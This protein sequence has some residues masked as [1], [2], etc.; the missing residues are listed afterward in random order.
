MNRSLCSG[1]RRTFAAALGV[2]AL[3]AAIDTYGSVAL[4]AEVGPN[5]DY[6]LIR[7]GTVVLAYCSGPVCTCMA[8]SASYTYR[9]SCGN[10]TGCGE[11]GMNNPQEPG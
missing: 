1:W 8:N 9:A 3:G 6:C 4:T 2:C 5:C 10:E 11:C 7:D